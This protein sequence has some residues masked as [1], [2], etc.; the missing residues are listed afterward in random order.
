MRREKET[1]VR[2]SKFARVAPMFAATLGAMS[3]LNGSNAKAAEP[4]QQELLDKI[5]ALQAQVERL[6]ANQVKQ[7]NKP[8]TAEIA[9][10]VDGVL[11][12]ADRRSQLLQMQGFTAGYDKGFVIQSED[13]NFVLKPGVIAQ[14][15]YVGN[16]NDTDSNERD[17]GFEFRRVRL[18]FDGNVFSPDLT[19]LFQ[20]DTNR[21]GGNLSLLDAM[22]Q[23]RFAPQWAVKAGQFKESVFHEKD[24]SFSAQLAVER[25]LADAFLGG[26][27]TDRVQGVALVYGGGKDDALR[28]ELAYHDGANSKNTNFQDGGTDFGV[29]G[30]IE[31]KVQGLWADYKDFTAKNTK[32]NLLVVGAGADFTQADAADVLRSTADVQFETPDALTLYGAVHVN[33]VEPDDDLPGADSSTDFGALAQVGYLLNKNVEAFGRYAIIS[34]DDIAGATA[35]GDDTFSEITAGVNYYFGEGGSYLHRAKFTVDVVYLPDGSPSA[36]TGL[37]VLAGEEEQFILRG[38][39]QLIL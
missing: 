20:W 29:G 19:Y 31:Y 39:F 35:G 15:R 16:Y 4:T 7:E 8:T 32:E 12:D 21:S 6:E 3:A 22:L 11:R 37:G 36:Q 18:R 25:S 27:Q 23:Y 34:F 28:A 1:G 33:Y 14:F 13:K 24:V 17:D 9:T 38:Q 26:N 10:T 30:R 5:N 2:I